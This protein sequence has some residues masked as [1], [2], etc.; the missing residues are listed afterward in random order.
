MIVEAPAA[1]PEIRGTRWAA[2]LFELPDILTIENGEPLALASDFHCP[3]IMTLFI[4]SL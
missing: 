2:V 1:V 4:A 3:C